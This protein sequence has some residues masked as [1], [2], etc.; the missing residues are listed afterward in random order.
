MTYRRPGT[1]VLVPDESTSGRLLV[2][3]PGLND[4]NFDRSVVL[5]LEHSSDGALGVVLTQPTELTVSEALP[6][7][8]DLAATPDLVHRGGPVA[9]SAVVA[10]ALARLDD[11]GGAFTSILGRLGVVDLGADD[12]QQGIEAVRV[13]AGY[14]GWSP[15]QL[16]DEL[17]AGGWLVVDALPE[18]PFATDTE[19]LW[20]QVLRRQGG[21]IARLANYPTEPWL[22]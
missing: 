19:E 18:D 1:M 2:A 16:D 15:L 11:A 9:P 5:M 21:R 6:D 4:P 14:S 17:A 12:G 3:A 7:W 10:L 22:N 20:G 13:Y 8:G